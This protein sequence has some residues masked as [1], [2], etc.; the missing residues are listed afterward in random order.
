M[1]CNVLGKFKPHDTDRHG[2][3]RSP[4][5]SKF[6]LFNDGRMRLPHTLS[7]TRKKKMLLSP[8]ILRGMEMDKA[9]QCNYSLFLAC[10]MFP[11]T[12]QYVGISWQ[13]SFTNGV[14]DEAVHH[15]QRLHNVTFL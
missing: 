8:C 9:V 1:L 4:Q 12:M 5:N 11:Q 6:K 13:K 15:Q 10:A 14:N 2:K 7:V 3:L